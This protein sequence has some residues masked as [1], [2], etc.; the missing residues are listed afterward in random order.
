MKKKEEIRHHRHCFFKIHAHLVFVT[1]NRKAMFKKKHIEYLKTI[2]E[3]ICRDFESQLIEIDGEKD[4]IHLLIQYPPKHS[5]SKIINSLK[6]VS[7]RMLKKNF[8]EFEK[9]Y[10]E[11]A[12]WSPS[13]FA[14]SCGE[15]SADLVKYI[16]NET[17]IKKNGQDI[18]KI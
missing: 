14:S 9:Y 3:K 1:K 8:P 17:R 16:T 10:W 18:K 13:Y 11:K 5:L 7:S 2:M 15:E 6:G 12:L 4:Y